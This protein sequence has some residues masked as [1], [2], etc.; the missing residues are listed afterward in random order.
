MVKDYRD[1]NSVNWI[2]GQI[3]KK[4]GKVTFLVKILSLDKTWKRHSNQIMKTCNDI[5]YPVENVI[6]NESVSN[7]SSGT[8]VNRDNVEAGS[9]VG[10]CHRPK[11]VVK[12]PER[13]V[14]G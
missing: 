10:N 14:P 6:N 7:P 12:P 9:F 1:P 5:S 11:R 4:I 8:D 13:F 2:K 3:I